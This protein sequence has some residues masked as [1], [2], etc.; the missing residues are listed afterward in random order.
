MHLFRPILSAFVLTFALA[1]S[2]AANAQ[3]SAPP[4]NAFVDGSGS[5][6]LSIPFIV[7]RLSPDLALATYERGLKEQSGELAGYTA[8][9]RIDAELP[10]SS[11]KAEFELQRTYTAPGRLE[12]RPLKFVGDRFVKAN[13]IVRL[14][15]AEVSHVQKHEQAQTAITPENYKFSYKGM[16]QL[17]GTSVHV[18]EVKPR[19]KRVGLFKGKIFVDAASG[20][21]LRAEGRAVKSPSVFIKR[22][23]FVQDYAT[24][25]G[26]TFP[27]HL[28]SETKTRLVGK[29]IVDIFHTDYHP[30]I[31]TAEK[32]TLAGQ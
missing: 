31:Q 32:S 1:L 28:H 20:Q 29:A 13:V 18:F 12:F 3:I 5:S 8:N 21:L 27:T 26:F 19:H 23:D 14:L 9:V 22:I 6:S 11:Q 7:P 4:A 10:S 17:N 24:I 2:G 15:E 25:D 16:A 30:L